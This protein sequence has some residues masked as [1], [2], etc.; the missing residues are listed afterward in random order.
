MESVVIATFFFTVAVAEG[1]KIDE[2][3]APRDQ[4]DGAG[5][6]AAFYISVERRA[7]ARC[8]GGVKQGGIDVTIHFA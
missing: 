3:A 5:N 1:L 8:A 6:R 4:H 2:L 7:D